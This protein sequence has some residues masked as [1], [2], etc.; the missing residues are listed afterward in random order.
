MPL[1]NP[2]AISLHA[3]L[4]TYRYVRNYE[5][6]RYMSTMLRIAINFYYYTV[7]M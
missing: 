3:I 7:L 4:V 1:L 6:S 2:V 5:K